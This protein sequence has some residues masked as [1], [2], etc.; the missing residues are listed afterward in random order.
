[1]WGL[2]M[3]SIKLE[4]IDIFFQKETMDGYTKNE[5][6]WLSTGAER[7]TECRGCVCEWTSVDIVLT[8]DHVLL[9]FK[10]N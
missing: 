4:G 9:S 2:N 5:S 1:M 6:Q 3:W 10:T 7:V 8:L